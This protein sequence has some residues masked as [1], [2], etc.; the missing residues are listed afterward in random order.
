[1]CLNRPFCVHL[2]KYILRSTVAVS[3]EFCGFVSFLRSARVQNC[4]LIKI[5]LK[6]ILRYLLTNFFRPP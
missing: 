2:K 4:P 6:Q 5:A 3:L 1:M